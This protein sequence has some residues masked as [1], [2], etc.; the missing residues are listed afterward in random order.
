M[1]LESGG[2]SEKFG[3]RYEANWVAY[4]LLQLLNEKILS[5]TVESIGD[6]E[7]GVDVIIEH[8]GGGKEYHQCKVSNANNEYWT[9]SQLNQVDILNN[10]LYQIRRKMNEFHLVSPLT[11]KRLSDLSDSALNTNGNVADFYKYQVEISQKRQKYL[12]DL[13][14]YLALD[15][16]KESDLKETLLFLQKF[17]VTQYVMN[18]Y[19]AVELEDKAAALFSDEPVKLL[20]FLK[21]Y[22][23]E[24]NKLRV[25]ITASSLLKDLESNDFKPRIKPDDKRITPVVKQ[26]SQDFTSSIKPYL[27][28][29][30]LIQRDE[31]D[32]IIESL[33]SCAITLIKAEA[34]MGKSALLLELHEKIQLQGAISIPIRLDRNRPEKNVDAFGKKLGFPYSPVLSLRQFATKQKIVFILDQLD[35]IR[36]TATHSNN[37]LQVCQELVRQVL[38][39]RKEGVDISIILA[40][41]NFDLDED[42]ALSSWINGLGE[43]VS[44]VDLS[45]FDT[46]IVTQLI[47]PFEKFEALPDEKK[48]I[49]IM[50][51]WLSVY[52]MIAKRINA[53]PQFSN[54]L[55]LVKRFW[56]DLIKKAVSLGVSEES[57]KQL[58]DKIVVL[59]NSKSLPSLSENI[60]PSCSPKTLTA[61]LSVGILTKQSL[62]IS[63]RHQALLDYQVGMR[64]FNAALETPDQLMAEI[65]DFSQQNLTKREH[66]KYALNML[67]DYNQGEYCKNVMVLLSSENIRFHLKYLILNS[68]KELTTLKNPAKRML[69]RLVDNPALLPSFISNSCYNNPYI[70]DYLSDS[71]AISTWLN[72]EDNE[73]IGKTTR[74][75]SS[76]AEKIPETVLKELT[77]FIGQSDVWN[78]RVYVGLCWGIE[79]DSDAMFEIRKKLLNLGCNA[80]FIDWKTLAQKTPQRALDLIVLLLHHYKHALCVPRY[81]VDKKIKILAYKDALSKSDI[82]ELSRLAVVIPEEA[83][84]RLLNIINNFISGEEKGKRGVIYNWLHKDRHSRHDAVSSV[85]STV[86]SIIETAGEQL[87]HIPDKLL[88]C[89]ASYINNNDNPVIAHL[90]AKLLNYLP[91]EYADFVIKWLLSNPKLY[92]TCG[93]KYVEPKWMLPAKLI[94][95][96]SVNCSNEL[97]YQLEQTIYYFFPAKD[98]ENIKWRLEVRRSGIYYSFWGEAQYFLLPKLT[99]SRTNSK[100]KQLISVLE[101]KFATYTTADFCSA[102]KTSGGY[103]RSPLP[104]ANVLSDRA[105]KHLILAPRERTNKGRWIQQD[106]N[107]ISESSVEQFSRSLDA[108]VKNQPIRFAKLALSLPSQIDEKYRQ[109]FYYG[110]A[111]TNKKEVNKKY[112]NEWELC[113]PLL[114]EKVIDHFDNTGCDSPLVRMIESRITEKEWSINVKNKLIDLA[115]NAKDPKP[116]KLNVYNMK[117]SNRADEADAHAL[118]R[119]AI[120]CCRGIAYRGISRLFW[121]DEEYAKKQQH[122]IQSA[123]DDPHPSVNIIALDMLSS[124]L[125]IDEGFAQKKFITLCNKDLRMACGN[126][127]YRFFNNGFEGKYQEDFINL[128]LKMLNSPLDEVKKE[129]ARQVFARWFFNDLFQEQMVEIIEGDQIY[130]EGIASVMAQFLREDKHHDRLYKLVQPYKKLVNDEN[131]A[132]L[133]KMGRCVGNDNFWNKTISKELFEILVG[134]KAALYCLYELF[135]AIEKHS[136]NLLQYQKQL[137]QLIENI[138]SVDQS[139]KSMREQRMSDTSLIKVLQRLYDEATEGEDSYAITICLDIW[140]KLLRSEVYSVINTS[141]ALEKGLLS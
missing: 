60:I 52:L 8:H 50:P 89:L 76:V 105:W 37:A 138:T 116:N 134:S 65:G 64:L 66:L 45:F 22:P 73:L 97:F 141:R 67:L 44:A 123:I 81:F 131:K 36:W 56:D 1:A 4:Q 98:L 61:L 107:T 117:K 90:I 20:S 113:P 68:I 140:D 99:Q 127:A 80:N 28:L 19:T 118:R 30:S 7:V 10:A 59:M 82:G 17:K 133:K 55:E 13:C 95:K 11:A 70:I 25:E 6:D 132:I 49:L 88:D 16:S 58:I 135:E 115:M 51:L 40:C 86:F 34:G 121:D 3:N 57:A 27:I 14:Q 42:I 31:V 62:Q 128:V 69:D 18:R 79:R 43:E 129:A 108:A 126:D 23:V 109:A 9:L 130:K 41:R 94:E 29:N 101:R 114:T 47:E 35:A 106:K 53:A 75:L 5:V 21:N 112:Q 136:G 91:T 26:I 92:F 24:F 100:T 78:H 110:L 119:N 12:N 71:G 54:K 93:N 15:I 84:F 33:E 137:L 72:S 111:N 74:L 85:T 125:N 124:M 46:G 96:F 32:G 139:N 120:N 83:L 48:D 122:L 63:F 87:S 39:L 2:Y 102:L 77:P 103:V 104:L 38:A